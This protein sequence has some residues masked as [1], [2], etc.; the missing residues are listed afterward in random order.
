MYIKKKKEELSRTSLLSFYYFV[1]VIIIITY[2]YVLLLTGG[3]SYWLTSS[4]ANKN[5]MFI[6]I[7]MSSKKFFSL[8]GG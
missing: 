1:S 8:C 2:L 6:Y 4:H 5:Y 3:M 7:F